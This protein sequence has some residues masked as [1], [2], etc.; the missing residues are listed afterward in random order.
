M[1]IAAEI[2]TFVRTVGPALF[3]D[4]RTLR[5]QV[6]RLGLRETEEALEFA[7]LYFT[8]QSISR[9]SK[10]ASFPD[11]DIDELAR[12]MQGAIMCPR[13]RCFS[14]ETCEPSNFSKFQDLFHSHRQ[15]G[16]GK[17][18]AAAFIQVVL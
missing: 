1:N 16:A 18:L 13:K 9:H 14:A 8:S 12:C 5:M 7:S 17:R 6:R 3:P 11:I 15:P 4:Y 2:R 10:I